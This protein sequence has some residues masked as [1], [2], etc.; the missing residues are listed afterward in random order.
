MQIHTQAVR[1]AHEYFQKGRPDLLHH[2][3]RSTAHKPAPEVNENQVEALQQKIE[4][5]ERKLESLED[6]IDL[7]IRQVTVSLTEG[8]MARISTLE[9]SYDRLLHVISQPLPPMP[10]SLTSTQWRGLA[11][12]H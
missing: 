8:Y 3:T 2:I 9:A 10:P 11:N 5:L 7:K 4:M 12:S 6:N 1:F